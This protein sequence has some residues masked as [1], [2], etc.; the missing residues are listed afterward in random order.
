MRNEEKDEEREVGLS[1]RLT[2]LPWESTECGIDQTERIHMSGMA[3]YQDLRR[4]SVRHTS[5]E[6]F[7]QGVNDRS[8][9]SP[10]ASSL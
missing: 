9:T 4:Y 1:G 6:R 10:E 3:T 5:E 2:R 7:A 8:V